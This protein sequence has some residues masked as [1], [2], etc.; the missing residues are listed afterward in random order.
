M[1]ASAA[2]FNQLLDALGVSSRQRPT[3]DEQAEELG[4]RLVDTWT[5]S[6]RRLEAVHRCLPA[7]RHE[8]SRLA[9]MEGDHCHRFAAA[10][11]SKMVQIAPDNNPMLSAV[12][13]SLNE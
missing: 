7:S 9:Q 13:S 11:V 2:I 1:Q 6:S 12:V 3:N 5:K 4:I 10:M 8:A